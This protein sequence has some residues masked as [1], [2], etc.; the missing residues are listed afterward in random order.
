MVT[1]GKY[2]GIIIFTITV[3]NAIGPVLGG[4]LA[5]DFSWRVSHI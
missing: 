2:H 5:E 3:G 1:R 4:M